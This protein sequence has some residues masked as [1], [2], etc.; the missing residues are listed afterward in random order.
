MWLCHFK[1]AT[2]A[3]A[4][5]WP[6]I[7]FSFLRC[8]LLESSRR[9]CSEQE[10]SELNSNSHDDF[11]GKLNFNK[12]SEQETWAIMK[13]EALLRCR[14]VRLRSVE[15]LN[16]SICGLRKSRS[17]FLSRKRR[18]KVLK[19]GLTWKAQSAN[20]LRSYASID[21]LLTIWRQRFLFAKRRCECATRKAFSQTN[22]HC[23]LNWSVLK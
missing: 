1:F 12:E 15:C 5:N 16:D 3:S 17:P 6:L 20:T 23:S 22:L 19:T 14:V 7:K 2:V 18:E 8:L 4:T 11:H 10:A 9:E 21:Y 13:C